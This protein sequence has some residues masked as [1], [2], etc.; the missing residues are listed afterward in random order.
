[1]NPRTI[2]PFDVLK[3]YCQTFQIKPPKLK[4]L[5]TSVKLV[6][7]KMS[8]DANSIVY[9]SEAYGFDLVDAQNFAAMNMLRNFYPTCRSIHEVR[10]ISA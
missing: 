4:I 9:F 1:M 10:V 7:V 8:L 3:L 5:K 6:G 2:K